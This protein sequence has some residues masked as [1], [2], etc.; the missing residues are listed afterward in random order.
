MF[1]LVH[2]LTCDRGAAAVSAI[3]FAFTPFLFAHSAHVQLLMTAGLPFSMFLFHRFTENITPGRG[4]ALGAVMAVTALFCG[5]YGI[6]A[7]LMVGYAA[8][9]IA[10]SRRLWTN[11]RYWLSLATGAL[12]AIALITPAFLPY[13]TLQRVQ[14]FRRELDRARQFSSNWSDYFRQFS[15]RPRVDAGAPAAVGGGGVSGFIAMGFGIAGLW[16]ARKRHRGEVIAIYGGLALLAFW[17][18]FGPAGYLYS[19]LSNV[20]C[21]LAAR[22]YAFRL[23]CRV[24]AVRAGGRDDCRFRASLQA[25]NADGDR[26][27]DR[28]RGGVADA[29]ELERDERLRAGLSHAC[30]LAARPSHRNTVLLHRK[31]VP[32]ARQVHD[33][34]DDALDAVGER[35]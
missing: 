10:T 15:A 13:T 2:L 29:I 7:I 30:D 32:A 24:R 3:C 21:C 25:A 35:L 28:R 34:F 6:F 23:D 14:G 33:E 8:I 22:A 11:V 16:V 18:S 12:V 31:H 9:V 26:A 5:Y 17:A 1:Y 4:A 19:T 20:R 27:G